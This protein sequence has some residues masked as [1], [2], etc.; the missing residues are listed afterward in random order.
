M[1]APTA[2]KKLGELQIVDVRSPDELDTGYI[3]G[4][5]N[6]PLPELSRRLGELDGTRPVLAVCETGTRSQDAAEILEA[7]GFEAHNLDSG[8]WGWNLRGLPVVQPE[9]SQDEVGGSPWRPSGS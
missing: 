5:V 7:A 3:E 8:M 4:A 9:G 2:R 6:I 1:D